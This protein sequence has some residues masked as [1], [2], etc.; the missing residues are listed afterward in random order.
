MD[1]ALAA[2]VAHEI[3]VECGLVLAAAFGIGLAERH[4][5]GA[6]QLLVEERVSG[7]LLHGV[8]H[9]EGELTEPPC[10][11]VHGKHLPEEVLALEAK[12]DV[13]YEAAPVRRGKAEAHMALD[14]RLDGAGEDLSVREVLLAVARDPRAPVDADGE[15][16]P[17]GDHAQLLLGPEPLGESRELLAQRLP[18]RDRVV[19]VEEASA[20]YE[21]LV[22]R[23]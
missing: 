1:F 8:V 3:P 13:A 18:G 16:G 2:E 22:V 15:I 23:E 4:V 11:L 20:V 6:A 21:V 17:L 5:H 12:L 9:P 10:A 14:A 7:E 19:L